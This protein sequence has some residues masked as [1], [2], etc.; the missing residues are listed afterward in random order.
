M[1]L[2]SQIEFSFDPVVL[3]VGYLIK[4]RILDNQNAM[5]GMNAY[6]FR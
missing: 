4:I 5:M 3:G 2:I 1:K 6:S